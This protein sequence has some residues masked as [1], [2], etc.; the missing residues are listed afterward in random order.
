MAILYDIHSLMP[1]GLFMFLFM[2][3]FLPGS[4]FAVVVI[5]GFMIGMNV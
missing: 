3:D 4:L 1:V 2:I 5:K